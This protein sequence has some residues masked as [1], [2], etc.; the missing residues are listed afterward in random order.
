MTENAINVFLQEIISMLRVL[1]FEADHQIA[2]LRTLGILSHVDE[3]GLE[4]EDLW[5]QCDSKR[6]SG[7]LSEQQYSQLE[8][9]AKNLDEISGPQHADLWTLSALKE[10]PEWNQV[11]NIAKKCLEVMPDVNQN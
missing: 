9:L 2:Y 4:F 10:R 6:D 3:L 5:V 8:S 1:A 11:R 7:I